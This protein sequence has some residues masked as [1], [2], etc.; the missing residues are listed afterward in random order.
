MGTNEGSNDDTG[1]AGEADRCD[2]EK[3]DPET[4]DSEQYELETYD[5]ET[6][7]RRY[8]IRDRRVCDSDDG[9]SCSDKAD[10]L[11]NLAS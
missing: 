5:P 10:L 1:S 4:Y 2:S 9:H 6:A 11:L 8:G 7:G 3:Y